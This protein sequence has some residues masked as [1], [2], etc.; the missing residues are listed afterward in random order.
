[1]LKDT[2]AVLSSKGI[3]PEIFQMDQRENKIIENDTPICILQRKAEDL[4]CPESIILLTFSIDTLY[5]ETCIPD[6]D[7]Q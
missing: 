4:G 3:I 1:M 2:T 7:N 5:F 6:R